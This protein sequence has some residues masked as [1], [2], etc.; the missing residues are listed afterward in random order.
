LKIEAFSRFLSE[1]GNKAKAELKTNSL[2][3]MLACGFHFSQSARRKVNRT[4]KGLGFN[5]TGISVNME[6]F[7]TKPIKTLKSEYEPK[8]N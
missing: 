5:G 3:A 8:E 6:N 2:R 7:L 4:V 1:H